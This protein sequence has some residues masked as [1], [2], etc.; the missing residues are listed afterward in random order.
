MRQNLSSQVPT[1][2]LLVPFC[3]WRVLAKGAVGSVGNY[4]ETQDHHSLHFIP[5]KYKGSPE[6]S[7]RVSLPFC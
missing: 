4:P 7:M 2:Q 3:G 5:T 6:K 1:M